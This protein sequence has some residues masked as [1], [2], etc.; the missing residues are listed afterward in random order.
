MDTA[1]TT[2]IENGIAPGKGPSK[3]VMEKGYFWIDVFAKARADGKDVVCRAKI[4]SNKGDPG[5]METAKVSGVHFLSMSV[6]RFLD[7]SWA[8]LL[9]SP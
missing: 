5:Y 7:G 4:G 6:Y 2:R 9:S 3:E 8:S 1:P